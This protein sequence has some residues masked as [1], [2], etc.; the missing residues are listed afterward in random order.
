MVKYC[1]N[2][3]A[4]LFKCDDDGMPKNQKF[5][6]EELITNQTYSGLAFNPPNKG[7]KTYFMT[8]VI[9]QRIDGLSSFDFNSVGTTRIVVFDSGEPPAFFMDPPTK[10]ILEA[11]QPDEVYFSD[12]VDPEG[13]EVFLKVALKRATTFANF[14]YD[15]MTL[16]IEGGRSVPGEYM[17]T[18]QYGEIL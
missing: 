8:G 12:L 10:L 6:P 11:K 2:I 16:E 13:E 9:L 3:D 7:D 14:D 1:F 5:V 18:I 17:L 4:D 15:D